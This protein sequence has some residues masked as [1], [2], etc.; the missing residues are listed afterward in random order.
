M[1]KQKSKAKFQVVVGSIGTIPFETLKAATA[2]FDEY[3]EQSQ[4][5][6]GRAAGESV[7]LMV[8]GE[9]TKE[10][11]GDNDTEDF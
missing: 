8:D 3:V 7:T 4:S 6:R 11:F 9:P 2:C 10:F 5:G 1:A